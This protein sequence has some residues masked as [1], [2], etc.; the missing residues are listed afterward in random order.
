MLSTVV[1]AACAGNG[2]PDPE[3]AATQGSVITTQVPVNETSTIP[4]PTTTSPPATSTTVLSCATPPSQFG[5]RGPHTIEMADG[6]L[7]LFG[8]GVIDSDRELAKQGIR[9]GVAYLDRY[10]GGIGRGLCIDFRVDRSRAGQGENIFRSKLILLFTVETGF[11]STRE[12]A[13]P[14]WH[15]A[16]TAAHEYAH[17]WQEGFPRGTD[18]HVPGWL[19]EGFAEYVGFH[20]VIEAGIVSDAEARGSALSEATLPTSKALVEYELLDADH[21]MNYGLAQLAIERL[22]AHRDIAAL[23]TLWM[24][25]GRM[26]WG[27][28]LQLVYGMTPAEFYAD[29]ESF[30]AQGFPR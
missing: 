15:L 19:R 29:F 12:A 2:D 26:S 13:H 27:E 7:Y 14:R 25:V 16:K 5:P 23:R 3:N 10:L 6:M 21:P 11:G 22:I 30:R 9:A 1:I 24:N 17:Y 28:A 8:D 18:G 20:A 4:A